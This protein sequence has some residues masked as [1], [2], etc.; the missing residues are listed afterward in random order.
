MQVGDLVKYIPYGHQREFYEDEE[1]IGIIVNI[2]NGYYEVHF[3]D[4]VSYDL[5]FSELE[6]ICK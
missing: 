2:D 6:V 4:W 3:A 1:D 5:I